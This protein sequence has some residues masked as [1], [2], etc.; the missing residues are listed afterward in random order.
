MPSPTPP[1]PLHQRAQHLIV[2]RLAMRHRYLDS[3]EQIPVLPE[4]RPDT[5]CERHGV[6]AGAH[7]RLDQVRR[8]IEDKVA[9]RRGAV[10]GEVVAGGKIGDERWAR[11]DLVDALVAVRNEKPDAAA[12]HEPLPPV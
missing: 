9:E 11:A 4:V 6:L 12:E 10:R 5:G 8:E 1:E 3:H 7:D 2:E